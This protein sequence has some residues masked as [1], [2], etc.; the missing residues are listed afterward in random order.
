MLL[1]AG[2]MV[3]GDLRL[4]ESRDLFVTQS[5]LTGEAMPVEKSAGGRD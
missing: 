4:V 2:D 1:S 3:P 5:A